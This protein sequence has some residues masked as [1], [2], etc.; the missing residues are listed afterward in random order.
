MKI[1]SIYSYVFTLFQPSKIKLNKIFPWLP[2]PFTSIEFSSRVKI[3]S[4]LTL[5]AIVV[6]KVKGI[7]SRHWDQPTSPP[8]PPPAV[9]IIKPPAPTEPQDEAVNTEEV[10]KNLKYLQE[11][12]AQKKIPEK[13][14]KPIDD[15]LT[16]VLREERDI[17]I[18]EFNCCLILMSTFDVIRKDPT[19]KTDNPHLLEIVK[20]T[21]LDEFQIIIAKRLPEELVSVQAYPHILVALEGFGA[22]FD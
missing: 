2:P 3:L 16:K 9:P 20:K 1:E 5:S 10:A 13:Y 8:P 17:S 15:F 22:I 12:L 18:P 14:K 11:I 7:A 6:Y 19:L 4:F 21:I